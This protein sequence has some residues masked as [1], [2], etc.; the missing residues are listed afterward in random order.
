MNRSI[1]R[2]FNRS[3]A[4]L[5]LDFFAPIGIFDAKIVTGISFAT[6]GRK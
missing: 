1:P 4:F 2:P 6:N 5:N 3:K